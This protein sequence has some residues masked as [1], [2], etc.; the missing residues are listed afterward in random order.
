MTVPRCRPRDERT[1]VPG[2]RAKKHR[3][4]VMVFVP[5]SPLLLLLSAIIGIGP[6][7]SSGYTVR[8]HTDAGT[9]RRPGPASKAPHARSRIPI[10]PASRV[11][12]ESCFPPQP[13]SSAF[14]DAHVRVKGVAWGGESE[15][16]ELLSRT[17]AESGTKKSF[18]KSYGLLEG[19]SRPLDGKQRHASFEILDE[20]ST[21]PRTR[22][23]TDPSKKRAPQAAAG[24][25]LP[26][27]VADARWRARKTRPRAFFS[28]GAPNSAID[29]L[30]A[31]PPPRYVPPPT[32]SSPTRTAPYALKIN[33]APSEPMLGALF[34][35]SENHACVRQQKRRLHPLGPENVL[36]SQ[37]VAR[38]TKMH[39]RRGV[40]LLQIV[41]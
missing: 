6:G 2:R 29:D 9:Q 23:F 36:A 15:V 19:S 1:H 13:N 31:A 18:R 22:L 37:S 7:F 10:I 5:A 8:V 12:L 16:R 40:L 39:S 34:L 33:W 28:F 38:R 14:S 41:L 26:A 20:N 35:F 32:H 25:A 17:Q 30:P 27:D 21:T 3:S 4:G 24:A 11:A